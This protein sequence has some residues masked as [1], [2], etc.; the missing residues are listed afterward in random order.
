MAS[1]LVMRSGTAGGVVQVGWSIRAYRETVNRLPL[2][3]VPI[4]LG[5]LALA[6]VVGQRGYPAVHTLGWSS[7]GVNA[8]LPAEGDDDEEPDQI[9]RSGDGRY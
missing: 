8:K 9:Y 4:R 1:V 7:R 3:L 2:V 6:G 5:A